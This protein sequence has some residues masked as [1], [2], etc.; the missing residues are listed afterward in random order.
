M[1][2]SNKTVC[3][4]CRLAN[5]RLFMTPVQNDERFMGA[6]LKEARKAL[7]QTSPNPAVGAILVVQNRIVARGHHRQAGFPHAEV[8]CLRKVRRAIPKTATFYVT[9]EPCS[10]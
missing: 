7:G 2:G 4:R 3:S 6:A 9:L 10:T 1:Q 5:I 8:E